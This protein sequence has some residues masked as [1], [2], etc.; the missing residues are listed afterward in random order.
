MQR[1]VFLIAVAVLAPVVADARSYSGTVVLTIPAPSEASLTFGQAPQGFDVAPGL[2]FTVSGD[3]VT[4]TSARKM[5]LPLL[6][7]FST[8]RPVCFRHGVQRAR[9]AQAPIEPGSVKGI[10][11]CR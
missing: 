9:G 11:L 1:L 5:P 2:R 4:I 3:T 10:R 6:V 8:S 7:R